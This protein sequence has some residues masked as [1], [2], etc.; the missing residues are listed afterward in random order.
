MDARSN[1]IWLRPET[2]KDRFVQHADYSNRARRVFNWKRFVFDER[3][4][5]MVTQ[6]F[7]YLFTLVSPKWKV[8]DPVLEL[9]C[10]SSRSK[11]KTTCMP[12]SSP[13]HMAD[14]MLGGPVEDECGCSLLCTMARKP[15]RIISM[16]FRFAYHSTPDAIH[17]RCSFPSQPSLL[18]PLIWSLLIPLPPLPPHPLPST[19]SVSRSRNGLLSLFPFCYCSCPL[20]ELS[21]MHAEIKWRDL[22]RTLKCVGFQDLGLEIANS[23]QHWHCRI[24]SLTLKS[25]SHP[26]PKAKFYFD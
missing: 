17:N 24:F 2:H 4:R 26:S 7:L 12:T 10:H 11:S 25:P 21:I 23:I 22:L 6:R 15:L 9:T 19:P 1:Q 20:A 3:N 14:P 8:L 5:E 18:K 16:S 13:W